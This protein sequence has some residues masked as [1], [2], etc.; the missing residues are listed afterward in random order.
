MKKNIKNIIMCIIAVIIAVA[1]VAL[2]LMSRK[3]DEHVEPIATA[4]PSA[5]LE[6]PG[7]KPTEENEENN[8]TR[9]SIDPIYHASKMLTASGEAVPD[10]MSGDIIKSCLRTETIVRNGKSSKLDM[11]GPNI[12]INGH[13]I[14]DDAFYAA[15]DHSDTRVKYFICTECFCNAGMQPNS[16]VSVTVYDR[17]FYDREHVNYISVDELEIHTTWIL[18]SYDSSTNTYNFTVTQSG[19]FSGE[20]DVFSVYKNGERFNT[21]AEEN[22]ATGCSY[23]RYDPLNRYWEKTGLSRNNLRRYTNK[24]FG[25]AYDKL[26]YDGDTMCVSLEEYAK[27]VSTTLKRLL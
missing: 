20:S 11:S 3:T 27:T 22:S 21:F 13:A 2:R 14:P 15:I 8:C 16:D 17:C 19:P 18:D 4:V 6:H 9:I 5:T 10:I 25:T 26:E 7:A 12:K 1:A 24:Y 23:I